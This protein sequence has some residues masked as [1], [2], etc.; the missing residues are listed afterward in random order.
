[1]ECA[2]CDMLNLVESAHEPL[3]VL[4]GI[5]SAGASGSDSAPCTGLSDSFELACYLYQILDALK[6]CHDNAVCHRGMCAKLC[7]GD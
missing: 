4:Q 6:Y 2:L 7:W 3:P 1:M 5:S